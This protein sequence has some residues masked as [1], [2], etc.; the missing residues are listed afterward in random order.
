[1]SDVLFTAGGTTPGADSDGDGVTDANEAIMGTDPN[2]AADVLRLSQTPATPTQINFPSKAGK[3][4]KVYSSTDL[5]TWTNAGLATI[6]GDGTAKQFNVTTTGATRRFYR[7]AV[8]GT[9][10]PWP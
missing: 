4:Y 3:F 7:L 9:D 1:V 2:N 6:A 8:M 5:N 10:G